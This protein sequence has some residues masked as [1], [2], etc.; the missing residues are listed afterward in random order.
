MLQNI[1]YYHIDK[2]TNLIISDEL[3]Q[4]VTLVNRLLEMFENEID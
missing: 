1:F 2:I 4:L 3:C